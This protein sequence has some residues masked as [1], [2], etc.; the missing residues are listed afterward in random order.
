MSLSVVV[1]R[2]FSY[3]AVYDKYVGC[4]KDGRRESQRTMTRGY[5]SAKTNVR[6]CLNYCFRNGFNFAGLQV[7]IYFLPFS[8]GANTVN[9]ENVALV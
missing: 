5:T 4:F 6:R 3:V 9:S 8:Y 7:S 2:I 1:S